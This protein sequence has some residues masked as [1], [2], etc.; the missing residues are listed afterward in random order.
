AYPA[1]WLASAQ[2]KRAVWDTYVAGNVSPGNR[3]NS[4]AQAIGVV[5]ALC[6]KRDRIVA[7]AGGLPAEVSANWRTLDIGTVDVEFGFSCMGYEIAGGWGARIAQSEHE[8]TADTVVFVG[9]GSYLLMNS[10]IYSSVLT[11]KK[12]II[13]VLDNGGFAVISKLQNNTGNESFNNLI[14]DCPTIPEP[15]T[16]DFEA[17]ARAMGA[18]SETV[19]NPAELGEAFKRAKAADKTTVI[20]MQV[21]PHEGWTTQGHTWWEV[22]TAQV[23]DN[24]Q[25]RN[26]RA[27]IEADRSKQRQGV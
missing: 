21:D 3:P 11:Q 20:V 9:D 14:A 8:P 18:T 26:K 13:L 15:F 10:D 16:V 5:N 25:V 4:Y 23:S 22:G 27:E 1:D 17:H 12:L 6:D 19:A 2:D 24:A 7:A